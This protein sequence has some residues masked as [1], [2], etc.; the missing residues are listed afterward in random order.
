MNVIKELYWKEFFINYLNNNLY[1]YIPKG[2]AIKS[3]NFENIKNKLSVLKEYENKIWNNELQTIIRK[4]FIKKGLFEPRAENQ[5]EE[6]E[7]AII[8][9]I[10]VITSTLGLAWVNEK[11][12]L[13][14]TDIGNKLLEKSNYEEIIFNQIRRFEFN[15]FNITRSKENIK[16]LPIFYLANVLIKLKDKRLTKDEYCLFIAKKS[17][18]NEIKKSVDEIE[19]YR[20]LSDKDKDKIKD[21]LRAKNI[22]NIRNKKRKSILNTIE[23]DSSYAF[24]FFASSNLFYIENSNIF[25]K[26]KKQ[27]EKFLNDCKNSSIWIDFKEKKDWFYYYG[28]DNK[29]ISPIEFALD[30]YTDISDVDN[31]LNIYNYCKK[32]KIKIDKSINAISETEFKSVLVDEKILEDFLER[33]IKELEKG[34][35]LIKRQYPTISG[36][37]D[38]LATDNKG[39]MVVIELKKNRVS[40]KVIGQVARYV[41]FLEREQDKEVRAIIIGKKIDNNIKLAV[42]TLSCRTDL[43][44][45]DYRVNFERVN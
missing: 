27:L 38:L 34:L 39:R 16:V 22:K 20:L 30:Y 15:N 9:V 36:P 42:N 3:D 5:N 45:F 44:N 7:N 10:K 31:A 17:D 26:D 4:E 29:N 19:R 8:R 25:I 24:N 2:Y 32:N 43:Y 41:S 23:L 37:I 13:H 40:D 14:I 6:D 21:Y 12:K 1:W 35:R 28:S 11:E 33:H 18:N